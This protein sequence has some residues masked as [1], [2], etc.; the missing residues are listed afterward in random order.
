MGSI[1]QPMP[2]SFRKRFVRDAIIRELA[3]N[4]DLLETIATISTKAALNMGGIDGKIAKQ[5][6]NATF[7]YQDIFI[8]SSRHVV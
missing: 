4:D 1:D 3:H 7:F 5:D 8:Y 6:E 2:Q